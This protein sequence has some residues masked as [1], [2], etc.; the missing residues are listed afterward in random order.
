M[1][2]NA[3]SCIYCMK[4]FLIS[5]IH[6]IWF[7]KQTR[8]IQKD[9]GD[10]LPSPVS[11]GKYSWITREND[12][13]YDLERFESS[14]SFNLRFVFIL[15]ITHLLSV[16]KSIVSDYKAAKNPLVC[17]NGWSKKWQVDNSILKMPQYLFKIQI[18]LLIYFENLNIQRESHSQWYI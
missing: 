15:W 8:E 2:R 3:C 10:F 12:S 5:S 4:V 17:W 14:I 16:L 9:D 6:S 11:H 1:N 18:W 7:L 13:D